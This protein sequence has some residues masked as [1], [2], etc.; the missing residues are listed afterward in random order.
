[1]KRSFRITIYAASSILVG[2]LI[3]SYV[4][5]T[6]PPVKV[7]LK[8][9]PRTVLVGDTIDFNLTVSSREGIDLE[10]PEVREELYEFDVKSEDI[11][12]EYSL[13]KVRITKLYTLAIYTP[14]KYTIPEMA[15]RYRK[16]GYKDNDLKIKHDWNEIYTPEYQISVKTLV[17]INL[18]ATARVAM[19]GAVMGSRTSSFGDTESYSGG[20]KGR[21]IDAPIRFPINTEIEP[22][23]ILTYTDYGLIVVGGVVGT[24]VFIFL[25]IV[26]IGAIRT[27][28]KGPEPMAHEVA[29]KDLRK[30]RLEKY[31]DKDMAKEFCSKLSSVL[32]K[33]IQAR[34]K[35]VPGKEL[36]AEEFMR[37]IDKLEE[38]NDIQRE[39]LKRRIEICDLIKYAPTA[40][41]VGEL[42]PELEAEIEL[43]N[44]TR[45][46]SDLE[47]TD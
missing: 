42:D 40:F 39:F 26:L 35:M 17:K 46:I 22:K 13:G 1:M 31:L 4:L 12:E 14:G 33:Y 9:T 24:G 19:G 44:Q 16:I 29:I 38:L 25:M 6:A 11:R 7:R 27:A 32:R 5:I 43:V 10:L 34:Y 3:L 37:E 41:E 8:V 30:L 47:E 15:V 28:S 20:E 23:R 18:E 36:T 21:F 45:E 2:A